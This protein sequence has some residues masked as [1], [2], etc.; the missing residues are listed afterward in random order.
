MFADNYNGLQ[1]SQIF[2]VDHN[3]C[4]LLDF[5]MA[6]THSSEPQAF[7]CKHR[8]LALFGKLVH[9]LRAFS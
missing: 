3:A 7:L 2:G 9:H 4:K 6:L 1:K 8:L 5:Q